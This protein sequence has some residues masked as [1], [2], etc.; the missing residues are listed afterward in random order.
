M[1]RDAMINPRILGVGSKV[2]FKPFGIMGLHDGIV[3]GHDKYGM[4]IIST[5]AALEWKASAEKLTNLHHP[6]YIIK[7]VF[8]IIPRTDSPKFVPVNPKDYI[9][10]K[11]TKPKGNPKKKKQVK[12][13]KK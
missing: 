10:P 4:P 7:E 3:I 11:A 6:Y 13:K 5:F 1:N 2:A 8:E 12:K 9:R